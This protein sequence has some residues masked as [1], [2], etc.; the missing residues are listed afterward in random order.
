MCG[1]FF[2]LRSEADFARL[3]RLGVSPDFVSRYNIAPTQ[4]VLAVGPDRDGRPA[5]ATFRWGMVPR[6]AA[7]AKR[8]PINARVETVADKPT[9]AEAFR[10]RRCLIPASGFYEWKREGKAKRPYAVRLADGRPFAFAGLWE[11]LS[12][13]HI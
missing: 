12:L 2:L 10:K 7:D 5:V 4:T 13:I 3:F 8:A 6:W 9:F 11:S 1:R